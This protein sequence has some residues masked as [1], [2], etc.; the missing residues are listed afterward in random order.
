MIK[1]KRILAIS[2][3]LLTC[4]VCLFLFFAGYSALK[5]RDEK[6]RNLALFELAKKHILSDDNFSERYGEIISIEQYQDN[7]I[8]VLS[9]YKCQIPCVITV[10]SQDKLLVWLEYNF[11]SFN[12]VSIS[13][14]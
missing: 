14:L 9:R 13:I 3:G 11:E 6:N 12:Y 1:Q 2:I 10:D 8:K 4:C 7:P 5:S